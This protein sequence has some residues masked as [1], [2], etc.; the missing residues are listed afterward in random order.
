[1][2]AQERELLATLE[3]LVEEETWAPAE[4]DG[5]GGGGGR[6]AGVLRSATALFAVI[7][8]SLLRCSKYIT[9]GPVLLQLMNTF[10]V[11]PI[12]LER[13][14]AAAPVCDRR[15]MP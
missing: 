4:L 2:D 11:P 14:P 15:S 3:G 6:G 1:M 9:R 10:Q 13:N 5:G 12:L 8:T 7:K